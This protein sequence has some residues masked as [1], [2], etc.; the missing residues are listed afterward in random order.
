MLKYFFD[1]TF[2]SKKLQQFFDKT[3]FLKKFLG[4]GITRQ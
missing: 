4:K 3:F 2:F 1:K